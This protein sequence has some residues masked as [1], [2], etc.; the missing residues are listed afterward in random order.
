MEIVG[1]GGLRV[2]MVTTSFK[3][4]VFAVVLTSTTLNARRF[5]VASGGWSV[6][7]AGEDE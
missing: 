1:G 7:V 5:D 2:E 6:D 4:F 3:M